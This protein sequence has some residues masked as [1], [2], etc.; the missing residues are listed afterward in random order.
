MSVWRDFQVCSERSVFIDIL[1][2]ATA[3]ATVSDC[4]HTC[5][6]CITETDFFF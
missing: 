5:V 6:E 1:G 3:T 4:Q 2:I